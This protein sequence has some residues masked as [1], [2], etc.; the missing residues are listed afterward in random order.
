MDA[1]AQTQVAR[2]DAGIAAREVVVLSGTGT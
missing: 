1:A 2:V